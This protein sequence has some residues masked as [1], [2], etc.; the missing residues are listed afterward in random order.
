[1]TVAQRHKIALLRCQALPVVQIAE[2]FLLAYIDAFRCKVK[3]AGELS[4]Q[5]TA[6]D[7]HAKDQ[8]G[9][10]VFL[11]RVVYGE[12]VVRG[13]FRKV[14]PQRI[15]LC[16]VPGSTSNSTVTLGCDCL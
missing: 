15:Q 5:I 10:A 13:N 12:K 8:R 6:P 3:E 2:Q 16:T 11:H 7:P 9:V 4:G 1:M 14:K